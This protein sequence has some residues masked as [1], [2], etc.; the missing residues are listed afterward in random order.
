MWAQGNLTR[1]GNDREKGKA[2]GGKA[3][4]PN[5]FVAVGVAAATARDVPQEDVPVGRIRPSYDT[6]AV[7]LPA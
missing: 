3:H 2:E 5:Q 6:S 4:E 1:R 7:D